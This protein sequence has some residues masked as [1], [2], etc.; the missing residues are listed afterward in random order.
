MKLH[1]E[2][3][4]TLARNIGWLAIGEGF[5][6]AALFLAAAIV[7][8]GTG[9]EG[10]GIFS[11][12]Y[13]AA[14]ISIIVLA[15]GQQEVLIREVAAHPNSAM[16]LLRRARALQNRRGVLLLPLGLALALLLT[17]GDLLLCLITFLPYAA[18]RAILILY[19]A[20]FKGL[21]RMDVEVRSRGLEMV[22]VLA[23]LT[24][25]ILVDG[26]IWLTGL[27][28]SVGAGVGL[29]WIRR[30]SREL[31]HATDDVG[32]DTQALAAEGSP[33]L[34]M[35]ILSQMLMRSDTFLL[36]ALAIPTT[37]IGYYAAAG[38]PVWGILALPHLL[39]L[40]TY[41][42]LSREATDGRRSR[43]MALLSLL[44]ALF[45]GFVLALLLY[46][47]RVPLIRLAFGPG[48]ESAQVLMSRLV[49]VIPPA[50]GS[51]FLGTVLASWRRQ[52]LALGALSV[53]FLLFVTL[54]LVLIPHYGTMGSAIA[55]LTSQFTGF[56][57]LSCAAMI[58]SGSRRKTG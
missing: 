51:V 1:V 55:A 18:F 46:F 57:I 29:V 33:F 48:F 43:S 39:A 15:S 25:L 14:L 12:A 40:A 20:T 56:L 10:L 35:S 3:T 26:P 38:A 13:A 36:A 34:A 45:L 49:W 31:V 44:S 24:C 8:R 2:T 23:L 27:S 50:A 41:P 53:V 9:A 5:I 7:A 47:L 37:E 17:R 52:G 54:N 22:V 58:I 28:F 4:K 16:S 19:G 42:S 11:I 30:K 32:L 21:D 6:K